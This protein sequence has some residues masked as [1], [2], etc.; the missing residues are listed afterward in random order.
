MADRTRA[1]FKRCVFF[2][3]RRCLGSIGCEQHALSEMTFAPSDRLSFRRFSSRMSSAHASH[4]REFVSVCVCACVSPHV[5]VTSCLYTACIG[6]ALGLHSNLVP[7][8]FRTV[9][10]FCSLRACVCLSILSW[11][12]YDLRALLFIRPGTLSLEEIK[13]RLP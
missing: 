5:C 7:Q 4:C 12:H 10:A 8:Q 6:E 3:P 9:N 2:P 1:H 13:A 11:Q